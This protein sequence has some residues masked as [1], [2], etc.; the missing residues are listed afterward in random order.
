MLRKVGISFLVIALLTACSPATPP[1]ETLPQESPVSSPEAPTPADQ[2][3]YPPPSPGTPDTS[4]EPA[5]G[6]PYPAPFLPRAGDLTMNRGNVF[7]DSSEILTLESFPPQFRLFIEGNL[8]TPCHE[9]RADVSEPTAD[10]QIDVDV[11]S[12]VDPDVMCIQVL[13]PFSE[14]IPLEDLP[15]GTYN[16]AL[17]GERVGEITVP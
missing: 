13:E 1:P 4:E 15:G 17:N 14:S 5:P 10:N 12:V 9:L 6:E 11:Y 3:A 7:I 16:V 2:E 8:P